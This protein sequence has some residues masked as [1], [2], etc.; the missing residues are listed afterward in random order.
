MEKNPLVSVV[1]LGEVSPPEQINHFLTQIVNEQTHKNLDVLVVTVPRLDLEELHDTWNNTDKNCTIRFLEA[2]A[3][4]DLVSM[5][6]ESAMGEIVF[7]KTC[8]GAVWY[9]RHI[10]VHIAEFRKNKKAKWGLSHIEKR[11]AQRPAEFLN[12]MDWR[13][14]NPP[15]IEEI[16]MDEIC[17][18]VE[19]QPEWGSILVKQDG[20]Q[21]MCPG[22]VLKAWT[23][24]EVLGCTPDEIT[25]VQ[26]AQPP[27]PQ[28][29][30][31]PARG[32]EVVDEEVLDSKS[33]DLKVRKKFSTV[34]GNNQL[35]EYNKKVW[36]TIGDHQPQKIAIKRT[37][38]MG[39][40]IQT[41]PIVRKLKEK[42]NNCHI[43]FFTSKTRSC[44]EI[45]KYFDGVDQIVETN[46]DA[47]LHDI[48]SSDVP[49]TEEIIET[50]DGDLDVKE[51]PMWA[52]DFEL[53]FDLDLAYESRNDV[54]FIGGYCETVNLSEEDMDKPKLTFTSA[55]PD[56][57]TGNKYV[58]LCNEGSGWPGKE[59]DKE[60]WKRLGK[61]IQKMGYI[62]VETAQNKDYHLFEN[63]I[64]TDGS[65]EQFLQYCQHSSAY[66][67]ADNGTMHVCAT[68]DVPCFV[69]AGA[70]L[71]SKTYSKADI[72]EVT[73]DNEFV[74]LK[75]KF[76][77]RTDGPMFVPP[78]QEKCFEGLIIE[79]VEEEFNKFLKVK[80]L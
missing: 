68:F 77:F 26:W 71:P 7:Y 2:N 3:G 49:K 80:K 43:T 11:D 4:P 19:L 56:S 16:I 76:F 17:H 36:E 79:K 9:P 10:E 29:I 57:V 55:C 28:Y 59:W 5:G 67:G 60:G 15:P 62:I 64:K 27:G 8:S 46:E 24:K 75:H 66:L 32:P 20:Q 61:I 63:S 37:M 35:N 45:V 40:V 58:I 65:F 22:M 74:G 50:E 14:S 69:V 31:Q 39:D 48:L 12:I 13:I 23:E 72:Y 30:A 42:Y 6:S 70:A 25:V 21:I 78:N 38:G 41:E 51:T 33:G 53:K 34:L 18:K 54:T 73:A 47:L 1:L 44:A 52:S